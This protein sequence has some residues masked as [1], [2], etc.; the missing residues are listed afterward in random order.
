MLGKQKKGRYTT[1][2]QGLGKSATSRLKQITDFNKL[3]YQE[4]HTHTHTKTTHTFSL[5]TAFG[6]QIPL[7]FIQSPIFQSFNFFWVFEPV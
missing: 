7:L 4:K 5:A 6:S 2:K 1:Q 3:E